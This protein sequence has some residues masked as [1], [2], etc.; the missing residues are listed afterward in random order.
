MWNL[1]H[2]QDIPGI[3]PQ[4]VLHSFSQRVSIANIILA[5]RH[6]TNNVSPSHSNVARFDSS[7]SA[8]LQDVKQDLH[9]VPEI[10]TNLIRQTCARHGLTVWCPNLRRGVDPYSLWNIACCITFYDLFYSVAAAREWEHLAPNTQYLADASVILKIYNHYVHHYQRHCFLKEVRR[11]GSVAKAETK[12]VIYSR[13]HRV[14][15]S[16][17]AMCHELISIIVAVH[18]AKRF[19]TR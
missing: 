14:S 2:S 11:P 19:L 15:D 3:P 7:Q 8:D 5:E 18:P 17:K 4:S 12:T 16:S 9:F 6:G 10:Y 1:W 13:R